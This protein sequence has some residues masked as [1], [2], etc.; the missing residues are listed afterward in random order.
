MLRKGMIKRNDASTKREDTASAVRF[1]ISCRSCLGRMAGLASILIFAAACAPTQDDPRRKLGYVDPDATVERG[2]SR[3]EGFSGRQTLRTSRT[4]N[5][6]G[7][8]RNVTRSN[9]R[10]N[11]RIDR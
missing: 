9:R 1:A 5:K 2:F 4:S 3:N 8:S 11:R 10:F 6:F 7:R